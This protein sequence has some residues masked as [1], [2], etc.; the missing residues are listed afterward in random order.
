MISIR[1]SSC[2]TGNKIRKDS[3]RNQAL[4]L[5][6]QPRTRMMSAT[7]IFHQ[8]Y[9]RA[10]TEGQGG[11][12]LAVRAAIKLLH[13]LIWAFLAAS[14]LA[15]PSSVCCVDFAGLRFSPSLFVRHARLGVFL[16]TAG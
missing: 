16:F 14:I 3:F 13:T 12:R 1:T 7:E 11:E 15:L 5:I 6:E 10:E 9:C 4:S 8:I 2:E